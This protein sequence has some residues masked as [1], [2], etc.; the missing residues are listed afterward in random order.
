MLVGGCG[1]AGV[2]VGGGG[3]RAQ[4]HVRKSTE[5]ATDKYICVH[6]AWF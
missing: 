2:G 3:G 4:I 1:V 6:V 5:Q